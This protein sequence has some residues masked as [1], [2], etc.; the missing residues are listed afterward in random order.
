[1]NEKPGAQKSEVK[2]YSTV[3]LCALLSAIACGVTFL[4]A[5]YRQFA[6][7]EV[8]ASIALGIEL[9]LL[10]ASVG[11]WIEKIKAPNKRRMWIALGLAA[12]VV[13]YFLTAKS[14]GL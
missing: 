7:V 2:S 14:S 5:L 10:S 4:L 13:C 6:L 3:A 11:D 1:M 12:G 8:A 9:Y